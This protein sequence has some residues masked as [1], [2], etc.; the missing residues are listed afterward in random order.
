[1]TTQ[2]PARLVIA[3]D[4]T[5]VE[6]AIVDDIADQAGPETFLWIVF[7][8]PDG[9]TRLRIAWT[10]GGPALGDRVD[11]LAVAADLD[12]GDWLHIG[13]RHK[14]VHHR[15]RICTEAIPLRPV[16][17]DVQSGERCPDDRRA[18]LRRVIAAAI[19]EAGRTTT[20]DVPPWH[21]FGP[22]LI[23]RKDQF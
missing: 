16:L 21:G 11:Q 5:P 18:G 12:A 20:P 14:Q 13:D 9:G 15:G 1:M 6:L 22:T 19:A 7:H 17:A 2:T 4:P 23:N 10:D 8:R 3:A